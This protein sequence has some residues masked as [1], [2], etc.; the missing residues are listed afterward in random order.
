MPWSARRRPPGAYCGG[1]AVGT[2]KAVPFSPEG[3]AVIDET[4]A[5]APPSPCLVPAVLINPAPTGAPVTG[6][7]IAASGS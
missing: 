1:T 6:T 5:T 4:L 3:N 2:T 7:Y